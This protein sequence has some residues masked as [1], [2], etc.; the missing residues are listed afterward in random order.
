MTGSKKFALIVILASSTLTVMAGS[1]LA[2][3]LNM[4]REGLGVAPSSVGLVITAHGLFMALFSPLMGIII[5]RKGLRRMLIV[6]LFA[7]GITGG[8]GLLIDSYWFLLISRAFFGI[9]VAGV[10]SAI[11]VYILNAYEGADRDKV[12]GWRGSAQ[13]FGGITWPL[14]GGFLAGFSWQFPFAVYMFAIPF[15]LAAAAGVPEPRIKKKTETESD[16]G[17][18]V[19]GVIREN[20]VI[21][22]IYGLT[23]SVHFLLYV[24]VIYLP[25]KLETFGTT[26]TFI[27]GLY[28][29]AM[30]GASAVI[31]FMYGKIRKRFS[32]RA[33]AM[34]ATVIW[35]VVF[36]SISRA[37]GS[38]VVA[39][40]IV[41]LGTGQGLMFP[42]VMV[43][44]G[45][46]IPPSFRGRVSSYLGTFGYIG[47]F[48]SPILFAP[49]MIMLGLN[50]VFLTGAGIGAAWFLLLLVGF[51]KGGGRRAAKS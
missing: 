23:F 9:T 49:V 37:T 26:S 45:D 27:I 42:T 5:D 21:L 29:T 30:A 34:T 4:M 11:N 32:Y 41:L 36:T 39:V 2:P 44:I 46:V 22:T 38:G 3:G 31:S 17:T 12:M 48:L 6:S 20:P 43:W 10:Y 16:T 35:V 19:L 33:I 18:S 51:R 7:Y 8:S 24:I 47:Q 13:S 25:Q 15:G 1:I 14:V 40:L 28:F 50:G